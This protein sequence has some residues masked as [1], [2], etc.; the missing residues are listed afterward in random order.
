MRTTKLI[1]KAT[2]MLAL[3]ALVLFCLYRGFVTLPN[4]QFLSFTSTVSG[5]I[6]KVVGAVVAWKVA[7][8]DASRRVADAAAD[9]IKK[10]SQS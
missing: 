8:S 4:E 5:A 10:E 9:R 6:L 7:R 3:I 1:V 2:A